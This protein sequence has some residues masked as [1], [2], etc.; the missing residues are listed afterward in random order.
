MNNSGQGI[1]NSK[2]KPQ[3]ADKERAQTVHKASP[4]KS[5][6]HEGTRDPELSDRPNK[7]GSR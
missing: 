1:E 2:G 3:P 4:D 7:S 5:A 6:S